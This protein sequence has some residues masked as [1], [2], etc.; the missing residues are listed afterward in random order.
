[1]ETKTKRSAGRPKPQAKKI[2]PDS[3][4]MDT[5]VVAKEVIMEEL[6]KPEPLKKKKKI[7]RRE[8]EVNKATEFKII[9]GGG[10][11]FM[12]P[13]KGVTI[14]DKEMDTVREIRYCPNEPSIF[15]DE[16]SDNALRKTVA[17]RDGRIF[18]PREKP[19]LKAFLETHPGNKA[20]GGSVF[21]EVNKRKE[22][23]EELE[24]EFLVNDAIS[25]VRDRDINDLLAISM[26]FGI[27][28][29]AP[30]SEIRY[31]LLRIAKSKPSEFMQSLDSPQV[32][33]R[34]TIQ[35]AKDYQILNLKKD[36]VYWFDSNKLIV[37]VPV[38]QDAIDTM[39]RF[40]LTE[41][42]ASTLDL[43]EERLD[44]LS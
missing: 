4:V 22:S 7:I 30:V 26:Y 38:G 36:G 32:S 34:S 5:P 6:D 16:Q 8:V 9:K 14:Y 35:Q 41:K 13:Q 40:C 3:V 24:K 11:V 17:F 20:N 19:N 25:I 21:H 37:S 10:I 18:V 2:T 28:I 15:I 29:N 42:G 23:L 27:N 44:K 31:N 12:L 1:M 33:C 39:V 43:I